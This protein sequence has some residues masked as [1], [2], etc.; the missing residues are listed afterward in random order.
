MA[1]KPNRTSG[2]DFGEKG[3]AIVKVNQQ[4]GLLRVEFKNGGGHTLKLDKCPKQLT[5]G[6]WMI[7]LNGDEDE[8]FGFYPYSGSFQGRVK[9]FQAKEGE[10]PQFWESKGKYPDLMFTVVIEITTPEKLK[11][12]E[13]PYF[14]RH[15]FDEYQENDKSLVA[16]KGG[17][18]GD[19]LNRF[20]T[21]TGVWNKGP[22]PW[23]SNVLPMVEKR[24][25]H[26]NVEFGFA[27]E[28]GYVSGIFPLSNADSLEWD[29][30]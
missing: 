28:D 22:M 2:G 21:I 26:E 11:E 1:Y 16:I 30:E 3:A 24:V 5:Q 19:N 12:V 20:L 23:K 4:K 29:G 15:R 6:R 27:I 25:L 13:V 14:L 10:P 7:Q 8:I 18:H 9:K 17:K